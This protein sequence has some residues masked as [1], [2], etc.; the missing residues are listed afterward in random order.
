MRV[1][2]LTTEPLWP[3]WKP[4]SV[5][6][7]VKWHRSIDARQIERALPA[8]AM[9]KLSRTESTR[10][11]A[12][13]DCSARRTNLAGF[14]ATKSHTLRPVFMSYETP[15]SME[16]DPNFLKH[17]LSETLDHRGDAKGQERS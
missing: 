16:I 2:Q 7:A 15:P 14:G 11:F 4:S 10:C 17:H 13:C 5:G 1:T 8:G 12:G 9:N 3:N 6:R